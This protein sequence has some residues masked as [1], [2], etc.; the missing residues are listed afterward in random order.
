MPMGRRIRF[1]SHCSPGG[2]ALATALAQTTSTS[3]P[4]RTKGSTQ[5]NAALFPARSHH[6]QYYSDE[7]A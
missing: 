2:V 3:L 7:S 1:C 5:G 4:T 6:S